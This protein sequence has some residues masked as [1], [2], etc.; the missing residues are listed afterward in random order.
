M[1]EAL[2]LM[3]C[4]NTRLSSLT[5]G[6]E[7]IIRERIYPT[8]LI[9]DAVRNAGLDLL[10]VCDANSWKK[11]SRRS[12]RIDFVAV[13]GNAKD[14]KRPFEDIHDTIRHYV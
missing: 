4:I 2:S 7:S 6:A 10:I 5:T 9:E 8:P 3:A 14:F 13:K 1:S 12:T 11:P